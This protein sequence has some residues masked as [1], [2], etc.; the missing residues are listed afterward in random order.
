MEHFRENN[1]NFSAY[2]ED[3]ELE[4]VD[5]MWPDVGTGRANATGASTGYSLLSYF[6]K[7]NYDYDSRYLASATIATMGLKVW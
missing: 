6:G 7:V 3:F 4:S 5:F 1:I 2:K